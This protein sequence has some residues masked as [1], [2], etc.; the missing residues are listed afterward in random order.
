MRQLGLR[1]TELPF[2]TIQSTVVIV[3]VRPQ[4]R[5]FVHEFC[6]KYHRIYRHFMRIEAG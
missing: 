6:L 2:P 3:V 5:I 1:V 4:E